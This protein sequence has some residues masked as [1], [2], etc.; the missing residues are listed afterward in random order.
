MVIITRGQDISGKKNQFMSNRSITIWK[1][2]EELSTAAAY[3]FIN[4]CQRCIS[5]KGKFIVALSGGATP[6]RLYQILATHSFTQNIPWEKVFL[7]WSDERFVNHSHPDSN[8][9]MT[10]KNLL[11]HIRIPKKN[12]FSIKGTGNVGK[13][14]ASYE[15]KIRQL[16]KSK[17]IVFDWLLLGLGIDG[18]TASLFP[19]S[20]ILNEKKKLV[21]ETWLDD[22]KSWRISFTFP[23]INNAV[24]VVFLISGKEKAKIAEQVLSSK[25]NKDLLP[26]QLVNPTKGIIYYML[27]RDAAERLK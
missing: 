20:D 15:K 11:D 22:K 12:I 1:D 14:A 25:N 19:D 3:F 9:G 6:A 23:L 18:H 13:S 2:A 26:A 24:R 27:D 7:F 16:F 8:Y 4:E 21:K 10:K 5:E 17:K